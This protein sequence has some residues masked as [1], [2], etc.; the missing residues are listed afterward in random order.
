MPNSD[1]LKTAL[2]HIFDSQIPNYGD[3]NLVYAGSRV[4]PDRKPSTKHYVV[5][6]RRQPLELMIAPF[7]GL[8]LSPGPMPVEVNM[9]NLSHAFQLGDGDYEV[10][11]STG[12][13]FRFI[14]R[15]D[16]SL[17]DGADGAPAPADQPGP[18]RIDQSDDHADFIEFM[19]EFIEA[20]A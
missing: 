20:A 15:A 7:N 11:T 16:P 8:A 17:Q 13:T 6:Y 3:Y 12:K 19:T 14:V 18:D 1:E 4:S 10:G 9:T 5:G 2:R